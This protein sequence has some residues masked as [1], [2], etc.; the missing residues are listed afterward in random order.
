M[1]GLHP[2]NPGVWVW[3]PSGGGWGLAQKSAYGGGI[4][5]AGGW[6]GAGGESGQGGLGS[7]GRARAG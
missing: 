4:Q 1:G 7:P 3:P 6:G 2:P 5:S